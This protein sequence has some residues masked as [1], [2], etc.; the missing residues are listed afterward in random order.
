MDGP[1]Y[2][3]CAC[4]PV[5]IGYLEEAVRSASAFRRVRR[6]LP[7]GGDGCY[8]APPT[9]LDAG[10]QQAHIFEMRMIS[11]KPVQCALLDSV[12]SQANRLEEA[13]DKAEPGEISPPKLYVD[14]TADPDVADLGKVS[15]LA[16]PH[17]VFDAILRD[18]ELDG[19]PFQE[20][21][22][23]KAVN[24]ATPRD[25]TAIF[26]S[27]PTTLVFGGW[28]TT[29]SAGGRGSRFQ[30][31]VVS[32]IVAI[33]V[34]VKSRVGRD[35]ERI[36]SPQGQKPASR[37]DPLQIEKVGVYMDKADRTAWDVDEFK[38]SKKGVPADINHGNIPPVVKGHGITMA[39]ARQTTSI[40]L[41]GLRRLSFPEDGGAADEKRD[42][43]A[44]T[45][46]AA[47]ALYAITQLD[48]SGDGLSLRS[49][50]DLHPD[51][52]SDEFDVVNSDGSVDIVSV[53]RDNAEDLLGEAIKRAEVA[54][55]TWNDSP[56][57]LVPQK[58]L[59]ALVKKSRNKMMAA[60][61]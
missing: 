16:A 41:A 43:A 27:S 18:S 8:V 20:S 53:T 5:D 56:V 13:L 40:T 37:I 32:E 23:G 17:R 57:R 55:L 61:E 28:N 33:D 34:P 58:K 52:Q 19:V 59:I 45:V 35:Q 60:E 38:G 21:T 4:R 30:R 24:A 39:F 46:L 2:Q 3:P 14:F 31:C 26:E 12:Q 44:R 51:G 49:R 9:Y 15:S 25:A 10:D 1:Y 6:L 48:R 36:V 50:C 11:G 22:V 54:G 47:L 7:V 42:T 29:G